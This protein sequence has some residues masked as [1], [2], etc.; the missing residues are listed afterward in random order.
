LY[1]WKSLQSFPNFLHLFLLLYFYTQV[2]PLC[3]TQHNLSETIM[4][5][6]C[7]KIFP[8]PTKWIPDL[9]EYYWESD[10]IYFEI[11]THLFLTLNTQCSF[12]QHSFWHLLY[13]QY[14]MN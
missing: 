9:W 14:G 4:S 1:F 6:F 7:L 13:I 8:L 11:L 5:Y 12:I 3:Y 2:Q 10:L